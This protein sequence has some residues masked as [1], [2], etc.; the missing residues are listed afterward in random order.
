VQYFADASQKFTWPAPIVPEAGVTV[1][2]SVTTLPNGTVVTGPEL[3][4][5]ASAV[6]VVTL[7]CAGE[8]RAALRNTATTK[9]VEE[10]WELTDENQDLTREIA[11]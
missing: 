1:A 5:T 3:D 11:E 4:A 9:A 8:V 6:A 7:L 2:V 10:R